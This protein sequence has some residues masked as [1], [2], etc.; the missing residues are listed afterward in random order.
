[1]RRVFLTAI[2]LITICMFSSKSVEP[3]IINI[4]MVDSIDSITIIDRLDIVKPSIDEGITYVTYSMSL[5]FISIK[6]EKMKAKLSSII[7]KNPD[8]QYMYLTQSKQQEKNKRYKEYKIWR[9]SPH[10]PRPADLDKC[11]IGY[12]L[13]DSAYVII[14][15]SVRSDAKKIK[16]HDK[17]FNI[18]VADYAIPFNYDPYVIYF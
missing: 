14:D 17:D 11:S 4:I 18:T 13:I 12:S 3:D 16:G 15:E 7:R 10:D 2:L 1:M 8:I 9:L 5:P 6:N